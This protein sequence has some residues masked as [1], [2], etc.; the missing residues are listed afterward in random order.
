MKFK[1]KRDLI[2][3]SLYLFNLVLGFGIII[4]LLLLDVNFMAILISVL[5]GV[6]IILISI[7]FYNC[8]YIINQNEIKLIIGFVSLNVKLCD[9]QSLTICKNLV[10]SFALARN[11]IELSWGKNRNKK[12][13]RVYVSPKNSEEFVELISRRS[14]LKNEIK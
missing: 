13:N 2:Y 1:A 6:E 12:R 5:L 7:L 9:I 3:Y 8:Y 10:F 14:G 4:G 11:R